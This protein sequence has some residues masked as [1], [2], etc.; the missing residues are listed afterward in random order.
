MMK[1]IHRAHRRK[2]AASGGNL[3]QDPTSRLMRFMDKHG[4]TRV[5][6]SEFIPFSLRSTEAQ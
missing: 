6:L 3:R 4:A 1:Y 5:P 2:K